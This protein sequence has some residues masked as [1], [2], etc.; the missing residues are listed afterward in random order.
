M[1]EQKIESAA[2]TVNKPVEKK[3]G[4]LNSLIQTLVSIIAII[5]ILAMA[6]LA[7]TYLMDSNYNMDTPLT[8]SKTSWL[9]WN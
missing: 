8:G 1:T 2:G 3:V 6:Y 9:P 7:I 4:K 5:A